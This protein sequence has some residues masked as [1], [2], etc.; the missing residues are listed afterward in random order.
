MAVT[1]QSTISDAKSFLV[2]AQAIA[3]ADPTGFSSSLSRYQERFQ[4]LSGS[5]DLSPAEA[6]DIR[7]IIEQLGA[8]SAIQQDHDSVS[9]GYYA[10]DL[11][12]LHLDDGKEDKENGNLSLEDLVRSG[13][14]ELAFANG[15][16]DLARALQLSSAEHAKKEKHENKRSPAPKVS[17]TPSRASQPEGIGLGDISVE[18]TNTDEIEPFSE[19]HKQQLKHIESLN[20]KDVLK[21]EGTLDDHELA[22]IMQEAEQAPS[23][24]DDLDNL[25]LDL[26]DESAPSI[27][28]TKAEKQATDEVDHLKLDDA[29]SAE[30]EEVDIDFNTCNRA[31]LRFSAKKIYELLK[32]SRFVRH[33][34][35]NRVGLSSGLC[36][37]VGGYIGFPFGYVVGI[38]GSVLAYDAIKDLKFSKQ[39]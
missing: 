3:Q 2:N 5:D 9:P 7:G 17:E 1:I 15:D 26:N 21:S 38:F 11:S 28:S 16:S 32:N 33:V 4:K 19:L 8:L 31:C 22:K 34:F 37:L 27:A 18:Q 6:Q 35:E 25:D 36:G 14:Q 20:V 10:E 12:D 39:D 23:A 13:R 24:G 29:E 30:L